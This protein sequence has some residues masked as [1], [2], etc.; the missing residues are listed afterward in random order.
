MQV[1]R[2]SPG[3]KT[4]W[5]IGEIIHEAALTFLHTEYKWV[6]PFVVGLFAFIIII[7]GVV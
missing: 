5:E 4:M 3:N 1:I 7:L 6:S 2:A